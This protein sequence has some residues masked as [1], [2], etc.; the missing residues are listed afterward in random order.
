MR[1]RAK[2]AS[3]KTMRASET[4]YENEY[5]ALL[6]NDIA[7]SSSSVQQIA[8]AEISH[9]LESNAAFLLVMSEVLLINV[10]YAFLIT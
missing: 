1:Y 9:V 5:S 10:V 3:V 8:V 7:L 2:A 4:F 6:T